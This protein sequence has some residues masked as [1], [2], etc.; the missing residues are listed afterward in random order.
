MQIYKYRI[1]IGNT[2]DIVSVYGMFIYGENNIN[3]NIKIS[4]K[5]ALLF[6]ITFFIVKN[7]NTVA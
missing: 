3:G 6:P 4:D 1:I 2:I 7:V 5:Y